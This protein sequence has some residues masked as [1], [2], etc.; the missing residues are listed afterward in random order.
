MR[1][2]GPVVAQTR[3]VASTNG[4]QELRNAIE[5]CVR[6][7]LESGFGRFQVRA[8]RTR[9]DRIRVHVDGG[10]YSQ[11]IYVRVNREDQEP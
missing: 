11:V 5:H 8:E 4:N 10:I 9:P 2:L 7:I 1:S 3:R 6:A